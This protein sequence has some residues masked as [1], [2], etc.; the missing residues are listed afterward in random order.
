MAGHLLASEHPALEEV[1]AA[2]SLDRREAAPRVTASVRGRDPAFSNDVDPLV[3]RH[4]AEPVP[5]V[6]RADRI[7]D[8]LP[9]E[10]DLAAAH[11]AR[12]IEHESDV[13]GLAGRG[14]AHG[15]CGDLHEHEAVAP[16]RGT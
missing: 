10:L 9:R 1:G 13:D 7:H 15:G 4:D 6:E 3:V 5:L 11:R 2:S 16:V 14:A 12:T 8:G